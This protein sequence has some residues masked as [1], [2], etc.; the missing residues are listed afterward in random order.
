MNLLL[1]D[2]WH[3][4]EEQQM[5]TRR[6]PEEPPADGPIAPIPE[7]DLDD[8]SFS[9]SE[10]DKPKTGQEFYRALVESGFIG[11]WKD[12]SDIVASGKYARSLRER[13]SERLRGQ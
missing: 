1:L 7:D 12:R 6:I 8:V 10:E 9:S 5:A 13:A 4:I 2:R 3:R 11:A